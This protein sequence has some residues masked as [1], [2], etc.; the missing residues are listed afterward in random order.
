MGLKFLQILQSGIFPLKDFLWNI[1]QQLGF[2][3]LGFEA[4]STSAGRDSTNE[5]FYVSC[6][7]TQISLE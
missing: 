2:R 3:E 7:E 5:V 1:R 4:F 6:A